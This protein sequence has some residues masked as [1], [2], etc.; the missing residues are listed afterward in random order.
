MDEAQYVDVNEETESEWDTNDDSSDEY[1]E[2]KT[3]LSTGKD[4]LTRINI[5]TS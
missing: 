1:L 3:I 5:Y 4:I 2:V